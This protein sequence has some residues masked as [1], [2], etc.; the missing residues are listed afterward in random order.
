MKLEDLQM[1]AYAVAAMKPPKA[2]TPTGG[3]DGA[4]FK[5]WTRMKREV[6]SPVTNEIALDDG[7]TA[8]ICATGVILHWV[9]G[10][11]VE[12]L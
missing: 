3:T 9:G 1:K 2:L 12:V 7:T 6:G 10:D 5:F 11:E 4:I 8:V